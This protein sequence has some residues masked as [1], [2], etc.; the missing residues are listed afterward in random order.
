MILENYIPVN[1][2]AFITKVRNISSLLNISPDWLAA[3]M[4]KESGL[5]HQAH[6]D[7][8][9]ATGLIQFMPSTAQALGTTTEALKNMSNVEQ[10]DY[11]YKFFK[12]YSGRIKSYSD[13]YLICFFPIALGKPLDWILHTSTL[14]ADIIA[15]YNPGIDL[16]KDNKI[17]VSEFIEYSLKGFKNDIL[18]IL[19]K[20]A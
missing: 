16:N 7:N 12:P 19:K 17:T 2:D 6:N 15:K 8:G 1:K 14:R 9:G 10:L 3:V 13:L 5:N 18:N 4:Y 20:K 11:V